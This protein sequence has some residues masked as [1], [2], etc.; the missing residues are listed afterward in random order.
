MHKKKFSKLI[1]LK[2]EDFL[3]FK[4]SGQIISQEARLIPLLKTGDEGALTSIFLSS[5][6]LIREYRNSIFKEIKL[7]KIG[8]IYYLTEVVFND[9]NTSS[10]ID[11]LILVVSK[12]IIKDAVVFEMKNKNNSVDKNQV[13]KYINLCKKIGVSKMATISNEFVSDSSLSPVNAKAP[14]N[15]S[16]YHFSWTYLMTKGQLLLF[17]NDANI[18]DEDQVEIMKEVLYYFDSP[19]SGINGYH[20]MKK[21]WKE[22]VDNISNRIPLRVTDTS[23]I[24]AVESWHEEEKDMALFLSRKLGVLVKSTNRNKDSVKDDVRRIVKS[25]ELF[26]NLSVKNSVS[27]IKIRLDFEVKTVSMAV[28]VNPPQNKGTIAKITWIGKQLESAKK[29]NELVFST[30][31]KDLLIEANVKHARENI[32]IP[33]TGFEILLQDTKGKEIQAFNI[34]LMSKF[35][36][37]FGSNKKFIAL[38]EKMVIEFY[39]G[40]V[41]H[42]A[43][44][45][46]PAPKL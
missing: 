37:S 4:E 23:L 20:M 40:I 43:N 25:E 18:K 13:E 7:S 8:K 10:R 27:N 12:G 33:I 46:Q 32:R 45:N 6:K 16:L 9:I 31:E 38:I 24:E 2:Y 36:A 3:S 34:V 35:N 11:G 14:R 44:W 30:L 5:I 17:K 41:Q 21:G 42:L 15:F 22:T 39:S 1:G 29:K 26:G 19:T 28:K